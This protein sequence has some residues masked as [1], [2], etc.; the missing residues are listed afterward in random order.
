VIAADEKKTEELLYRFDVLLNEERGVI[1]NGDYDALTT[2]SNQKM[3][4]LEALRESVISREASV[5]LRGV[6]EKSAENGLMVESALRFWRGAHQ[7]LMRMQGQV[8]QTPL[9]QRRNAYT[10]YGEQGGGR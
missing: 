8:A 10:L 4:L 1:S 5:A 7:K 6:L 3:E 9:S 2:I